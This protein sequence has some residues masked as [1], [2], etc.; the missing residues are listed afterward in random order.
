MRACHV[1]WFWCVLVAVCRCVGRRRQSSSQQGLHKLYGHICALE[2]TNPKVSRRL[3]VGFCFL[4]A[5]SMLVDTRSSAAAHHADVLLLFT[6]LLQRVSSCRLYVCLC[7]SA[8]VCASGLSRGVA[9]QC[10]SHANVQYVT[11]RLIQILWG[12]YGEYVRTTISKT[13]PLTA[14]PDFQCKAHVGLSGDS[15]W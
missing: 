14:R 15:L 9:N 4:P 11:V 6:S 7:V 3:A 10:S 1:L 2:H 13:F 5:S 12:V 8:S